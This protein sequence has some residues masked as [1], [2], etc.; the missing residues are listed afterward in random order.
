MGA[1]PWVVKNKVEPEQ[2]VEIA[3]E[4][5]APTKPGT[6]QSFFRLQHSDNIEFGQKVWVVL[7]VEEE[8]KPVKIEEP[9]I[10]APVVEEKSNT[11]QTSGVEAKPTEAELLMRS[12]KMIDKFQNDEDLNN[13]VE[14]DCASVKSDEPVIKEENPLKI[15]VTDIAQQEVNKEEASSLVEEADKNLDESIEFAKEEPMSESQAESEEPKEEAKLEEPGAVN[16]M[17]VSVESNFGEKF[18]YLEQVN[19]GPAQFRENLIELMNMGFTNFQ[20][21]MTLL[22]LHNNNL[23][24]VCSELLEQ[25]Q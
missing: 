7:K 8:P 12:Q 15:S 20:V 14:L 6:Y 23:P 24:M 5:V 16:Q 11:L 21:N 19:Q 25:G 2:E 1:I 10:F 18:S 13:S 3:V 4:F 22:Q 17:H 9:L